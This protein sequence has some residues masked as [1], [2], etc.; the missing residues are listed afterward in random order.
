[1]RGDKEC[2][3]FQQSLWGR[4]KMAKF[5]EYVCVVTLAQCS[6]F[7]KTCVTTFA[8]SHKHIFII[9]QNESKCV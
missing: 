2:G 3:S 1:M 4:M 7:H 9:L 5:L 6:V 8:S